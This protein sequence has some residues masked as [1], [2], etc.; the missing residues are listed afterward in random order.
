[1]DILD[2]RRYICPLV[3][4]FWKLWQIAL[5]LARDKNNYCQLLD[6]NWTVALNTVTL[7]I[8]GIVD[9]LTS[10]VVLYHRPMPAVATHRK[11][12]AVLQVLPVIQRLHTQMS[13]GIK[14]D[15]HHFILFHIIFPS[16]PCF[17]NGPLTNPH[18][19]HGTD[20][21]L[22]RRGCWEWTK[23][24]WQQAMNQ[25]KT[26]VY[27][28]ILY[29]NNC[30]A[31]DH[32]VGMLVLTVIKTLNLHCRLKDQ[33]WCPPSRRG[34]LRDSNQPRPSL[35]GN[36]H[37]TESCLLVEH[38]SCQT[39]QTTSW[40]FKSSWKNLDHSTQKGWP[41]SLSLQL[42]P[43][44]PWPTSHLEHTQRS[45]LFFLYKQQFTSVQTEISLVS[46]HSPLVTHVTAF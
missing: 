27:M 34:F 45:T 33:A 12:V 2:S 40:C 25:T 36:V 17:G 16:Q 35:P 37:N 29:S 23:L 26:I 6:S 8:C 42:C 7:L 5:E 15:S 11:T 10:S 24:Q 13:K 1:M 22:I 19:E 4:K 38:P 43:W 21:T 41:P 20:K 32:I 14:Q 28:H 30:Q 31:V 44:M 9:L 18:D 39:F 46:W 3:A